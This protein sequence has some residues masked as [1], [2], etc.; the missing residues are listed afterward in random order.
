MIRMLE[1]KIKEML[2]GAPEIHVIGVSGQEARAV[3]DYL[4]IFDSERLVGHENSPRHE[5]NETFLR[6]SDAYSKEEA[7]V[8]AERFLSSGRIRFKE[9]YLKGISDGSVVIVSQAYRRYPSNAPLIEAAKEGR[10]KIIQVMEVAFAVAPCLTIGV[11]G[12][13]GKS[14]V[15]SLLKGIIEVSCRPA[16]FSGND[17]DNKWDLFALEKLP[18]EGIALFEVSHRH[19]M[20]LS[21]SPNIA[22]I[23]NI[24]PHHLDDAG[25]FD[26]YAAIK[27]NI[28]RFQT[29]DDA[30]IVNSELIASNLI[31]EE[32]IPGWLFI[33]GSEGS[34]CSV[35]DGT[36]SISI[37]GTEESVIPVSSL[38]LKGNHNLL[39]AE[40]AVMASFSAGIPVEEIRA[41][42]MAWRPLKYRMEKLP[43][44]G[45][46]EAWNDGKSSDPLATIEAVK[47]VS[48]IKALIMGGIREG[49][50]EGDF[51]EL[52]KE[53][54]FRGVEKVFIYGKSR[55]L[56]KTDLL[57]ALDSRR[58]VECAD[59]R[60]AIIHASSFM[61]GEG[62][63]LFSPACQSFDGFKDYRARAE[64]FNDN[65][66][67]I[68]SRK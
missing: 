34:D 52:A 2:S 54:A 20:D 13:A 35:S 16:Y 59:L 60:D 46:V 15:C 57:G 48:G 58:V 43:N 27:K 37:E 23:T 42:I 1:G 32:E 40:A 7:E 65:L 63:L 64:F 19:L 24:Y 14:T 55:E 49:S 68:F 25:S 4:L 6:Y 12:T 50:R 61:K 5:F 17:R 30:L 66:Q 11:T 9:D 45:N 44:I 53:I 67:S 38:P 47:S 36:V 62:R 31:T 3:F 8:M 10:I 33:F 39:N 28:F 21:V 29:A 51:G 56:I 41:G 26:N 22:V 18:K